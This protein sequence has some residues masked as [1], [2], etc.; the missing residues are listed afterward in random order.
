MRFSEGPEEVKCTIPSELQLD[1]YI[2]LYILS[3]AFQSYSF[4]M[5]MFKFLY[6]IFCLFS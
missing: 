1:L 5:Q 3:G 6:G 4:P 2:Y